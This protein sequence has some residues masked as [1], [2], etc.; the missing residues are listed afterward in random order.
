MMEASSCGKERSSQSFVALSEDGSGRVGELKYSG[1]LYAEVAWA[2]RKTKCFAVAVGS[3]L[4]GSIGGA[5][6]GTDG[7]QL[8]CRWS[9]SLVEMVSPF[10]AVMAMRGEFCVFALESRRSGELLRN[11]RDPFQ[12]ETVSISGFLLR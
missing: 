4:G 2:S 10:F 6:G 5:I 8:V 7:L 12:K 1:G 11:S 3:G 9:K